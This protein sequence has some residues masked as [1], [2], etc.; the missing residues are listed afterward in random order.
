[1]EDVLFYTQ[2]SRI[3]AFGSTSGFLHH[4]PQRHGEFFLIVIHLLPPPS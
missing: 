3:E 2:L 1:M 4:L